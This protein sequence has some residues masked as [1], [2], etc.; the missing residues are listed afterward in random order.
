MSRET[1]ESAP[2]GALDPSRPVV[3][4]GEGERGPIGPAADGRSSCGGYSAG[5]RTAKRCAGSQRVESGE[6]R[7]GAGGKRWYAATV[8][9]VL[10]C[11]S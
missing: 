11:T 2:R 5:A 3:L 8:P 7:H 1:V 6:S 9:H 10:I 4:R